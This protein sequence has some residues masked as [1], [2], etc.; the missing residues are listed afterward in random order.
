MTSYI[1]HT[2][3]RVHRK[4]KQSVLTYTTTVPR[5]NTRSQ[6]TP[7]MTVEE[8]RKKLDRSRYASLREFQMDFDALFAGVFSAVI[9]GSKKREAAERLHRLGARLIQVEVGRLQGKRQLRMKIEKVNGEGVKKEIEATE[10]EDNK[11]E[12]M[13]EKEDAMEGDEQ[14]EESHKRKRGEG[15]R[16]GSE[17]SSSESANS[18][19]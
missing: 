10:I 1:Y 11:E 6:Q 7:T 13:S 4:D 18:E 15:R 9:A 8:V 2:P 3:I 14:E 5:R 17:A 12:V 16:K 19:Q